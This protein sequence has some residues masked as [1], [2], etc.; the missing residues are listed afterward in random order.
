MVLAT[1][2]WDVTLSPY[3]YYTFAEEG[4]GYASSLGDLNNQSTLEAVNQTIT[5]A[6]AFF[7]ENLKEEEAEDGAEDEVSNN[8]AR[9]Q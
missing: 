4:H 3:R 8:D 2:W 9:G 5:L 6:S 7:I 1:Q